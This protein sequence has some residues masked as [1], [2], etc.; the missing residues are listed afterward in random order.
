MRQWHWTWDYG[1]RQTTIG[2]WISHG[3]TWYEPWNQPWMNLESSVDGLGISHGWTWNESWDKSAMDGRRRWTWDQPW[4]NFEWVLGS[5][6]DGRRGWTWDQPWMDILAGLGDQPWMNLEWVLGV[7]LGLAEPWMDLGI[8]HELMAWAK[9][10]ATCGFFIRLLWCNFPVQTDFWVS[11]S[12]FSHSTS[13][14]ANFST[15]QARKQQQTGPGSYKT[16]VRLQQ[17]HWLWMNCGVVQYSTVLYIQLGFFGTWWL[18]QFPWE[19][20]WNSVLSCAHF[21]VDGC[22]PGHS[23]EQASGGL[24]GRRSLVLRVDVLMT[25]GPSSCAAAVMKCVWNARGWAT[26][27]WKSTLLVNKKGSGMGL[28]TSDSTRPFQ[29][30]SVLLFCSFLGMAW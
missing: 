19:G 27:L 5:A 6:M 3:W 28:A 2:C 21:V 18:F 25:E 26:T 16:S 1:N 13:T 14:V 24:W 20:G 23:L 12:K 11:Q 22:L 30:Y 10:P 4:M 15:D 17:T 9:Q 29:K 7:D 8:G